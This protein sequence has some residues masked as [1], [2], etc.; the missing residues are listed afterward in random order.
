MQNTLVSPG[1]AIVQPRSY[2][3]ATNAAEFQHQLTTAV[4]PP[5]VSSLLV[6]MKQVEYID[7]AG[8]MALVTALNA[9]QRLKRRFSLC[10]VSPSVRMIF[11]LT[12]LD[13]AFEMFE[14]RE[15]YEA[16]Q[17]VGFN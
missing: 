13:R 9:A 16:A 1:V 6:D 2:I 3:N 11:E 4:S 5:Q 8:L 7:S 17:P 12:Q 15:A 14:S 10:C